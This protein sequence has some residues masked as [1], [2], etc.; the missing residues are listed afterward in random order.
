MIIDKEYVLEGEI[1]T[2][3][4]FK[5]ED[6]SELVIAKQTNLEVTKDQLLKVLAI[7]KEPK[8][9]IGDKCFKPFECEYKHHCWKE[10]PEYSIFNIYQNKKAE[11]VAKKIG[12]YDIKD[13]E[14]KL[15]PTGAKVI[16]IKCYQE[17]KTHLEKDKI[18]NWLKKLQY[19]LYFLD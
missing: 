5:F 4:F 7:E 6:V 8:I 15:F 17:G 1:D 11:E 10:I 3:K 14:A 2:N 19:P 12:S 18:K 13:I 16:D 9:E